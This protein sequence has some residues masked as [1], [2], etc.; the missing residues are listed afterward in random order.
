MEQ[1]VLANY[2][3]SCGCQITSDGIKSIERRESGHSSS[4]SRTGL[5]NFNLNQMR[6]SKRKYYRDVAVYYCRSCWESKRRIESISIILAIILVVGFFIYFFY[7]SGTD[8]SNPTQ[9][10]I[11]N[12]G[13]SPRLEKIFL[14][15]AENSNSLGSILDG[16]LSG[17]EKNTTQLNIE[18]SRCK[19]IQ[20]DLTTFQTKNN[21]LKNAADEF[22]KAEHMLCDYFGKVLSI[23]D[24][25]SDSERAEAL[26]ALGEDMQKNHAAMDDYIQKGKELFG[27]ASSQ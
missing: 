4:V 8:K 19:D 22:A 21:A 27:K 16:L 13:D 1:I 26:K 2:C 18:V 12:S 7:F 23:F 20:H 15:S 24:Q 6:F 3:D 11:K 14:R 17:S 10:V 5:F 25:L 9:S